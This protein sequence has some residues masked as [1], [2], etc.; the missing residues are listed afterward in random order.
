MPQRRQGFHPPHIRHGAPGDSMDKECYERMEP[1]DAS[2][3]HWKP[4][5]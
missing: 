5:S 2:A 3:R 4:Q 1:P